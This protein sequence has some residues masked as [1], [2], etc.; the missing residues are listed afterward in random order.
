MI[1][2]QVFFFDDIDS[3]DGNWIEW[4]CEGKWGGSVSGVFDGVVNE[5]EEDILG[6]EDWEMILVKWVCELLI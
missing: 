4:E 6:D 5:Y 2:E 3:E 1:H